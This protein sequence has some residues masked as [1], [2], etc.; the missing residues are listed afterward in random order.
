MG[1]K[2]SYLPLRKSSKFVDGNWFMKNTPTIGEG[3]I[4]TVHSKK[5]I[6]A[7]VQQIFRLVSLKEAPN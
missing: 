5:I 1:Q 3:K 7:R 4:K 6:K 2:K